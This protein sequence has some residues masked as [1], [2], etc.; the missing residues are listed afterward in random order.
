M[1]NTNQAFGFRPVRYL[2]GAPW[3]GKFRIYYV[4]TTNTASILIGDP[5]SLQH[6]A[7]T[8]KTYV[9]PLGKYQSATIAAAGDSYYFCG[10]CVAA[11]KDPA[12]LFNP[13]DLYTNWKPDTPGAANP[14]YI[15]VVDDPNIIYQVQDDASAAP[16]T[17]YTY[18]DINNLG[19]NFDI[20]TITTSVSATASLSTAKI[21][22]STLATTNTLPWRLLGLADLT[23]PVGGNTQAIG[24]SYCVWEV[25]PNQTCYKVG[26]TA[27]AAS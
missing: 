16:S 3:N 27:H 9:D 1:A 2:N 22:I 13:T 11:G 10:V 26:A 20:A 15:G 21:A 23:I 18:I 25:I 4:G 6:A 19:M 14:Y 12:S 17:G 24:N 8:T 7:Y 5:V